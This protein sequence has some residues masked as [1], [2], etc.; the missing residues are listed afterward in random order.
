MPLELQKLWYIDRFGAQ[1]ICK[2]G[3]SAKE[4]R[5]M[6]VSE[7]IVKAYVERKNSSNW[8]QWA[9]DNQQMSRLL[10]TGALLNG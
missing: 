7:N 8:A 1:I 3:L 2:N 4:I 5:L 10:E 9:K 6:M